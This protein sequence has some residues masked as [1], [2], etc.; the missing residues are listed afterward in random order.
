MKTNGLARHMGIR[1]L[2][3]KTCEVTNVIGL[4]HMFCE[5]EIKKKNY[6]RN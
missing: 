6:I 3:N 4:P 5:P 2:A 1:P